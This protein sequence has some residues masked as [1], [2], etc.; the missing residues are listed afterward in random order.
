MFV[1][2]VSLFQT[3]ILFS[4]LALITYTVI[5]MGKKNASRDTWKPSPSKPTMA[6]MMV[7]MERIR[8]SSFAPGWTPCSFWPPSNWRF[9]WSY[10]CCPAPVLGGGSSE[11]LPCCSAQIKMLV[12]NTPMLSLD[13]VILLKL[14]SESLPLGSGGEDH[15][16]SLHGKN[17]PVAWHSPMP[18]LCALFQQLVCI[19]EK[20]TYQLLW[21]FIDLLPFL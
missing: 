16:C 1:E 21:A 6:T 20:W 8:R 19:T 7:Q 3:N 2:F 13:R 10:V 12:V 11:E 14:R 17:R 18:V 9:L 5:I 4:K 15:A